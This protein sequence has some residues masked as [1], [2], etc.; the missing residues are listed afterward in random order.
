MFLYL[1]PSCCIET[2]KNA[3][4]TDIGDSS[5]ELSRHSIGSVTPGS[6]SPRSIRSTHETVSRKSSTQ[7]TASRISNTSIQSDLRPQETVDFLAYLEDARRVISSCKTDCRCWSA[8]YDGMDVMT[9]Y[10]RNGQLNHS[11]TSS[12]DSPIS[13]K[14][15]QSSSSD[16][17]FADNLNRKKLDSIYTT[18]IL[19]PFLNAIFDKIENMI[20]NDVYVNLL[21]TSLVSRL[22]CYP[23]PLLRSFSIE[24]ESCYTTWCTVFGSGER[25]EF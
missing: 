14:R 17:V 24:F 10:P 23:Q 9:E 3:K 15:N 2:N 5:P 19:G 4:T 7:S 12:V 18:E 21:L 25:V 13:F 16:N 6:A 8:V 1:T 22:A 11:S 20:E